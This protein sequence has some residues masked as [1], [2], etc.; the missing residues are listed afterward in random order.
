MLRA[1]EKQP[2]L[3]ESIQINHERISIFMTTQPMTLEQLQR[4]SLQRGYDVQ[5]YATAFQIVKQNVPH[6]HTVISLKPHFSLDQDHAHDYALLQ[7][8]Y[9]V[10]GYH[11]DYGDDGKIAIR[12]GMLHPNF[13][14]SVWVEKIFDYSW[15]AD[16]DIG[17]LHEVLL[18]WVTEYEQTELQA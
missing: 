11:L 5:V 3:V 7:G 10:R 16:W 6:V 18:Q 9:W 13:D 4:E 8:Y 17:Q 15:D 2:D 14:Q 1:I 12:R